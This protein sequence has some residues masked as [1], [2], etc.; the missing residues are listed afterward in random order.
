MV[1]GPTPGTLIHAETATFSR[2]DVGVFVEASITVLP[3]CSGK[4]CA[5][6]WLEPNPDIAG[7]GVC[8]K[9]CLKERTRML[10]H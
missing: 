7:L 3:N 5:G 1:L 9:R 2:N 8:V 10:R 4:M 6:V